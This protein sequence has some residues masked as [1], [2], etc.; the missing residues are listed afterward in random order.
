M[1]DK[2]WMMDYMVNNLQAII[3]E[4]GRTQGVLQSNTEDTLNVL[5]KA[6]ASKVG[7]MIVRN[8]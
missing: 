6:T 7:S 5:V 3:F 8:S 4:R 1:P 2:E